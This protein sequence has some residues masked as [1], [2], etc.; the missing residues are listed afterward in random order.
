MYLALLSQTGRHQPPLALL[1]R[2]TS[3]CKPPSLCLVLGVW[4]GDSA[5]VARGSG[6]APA[7]AHRAAPSLCP[8]KSGP[9]LCFLHR[10]FRGWPRDSAHYVR[11]RTTGDGGDV[12]VP[13]G[14]DLAGFRVLRARV[15]LATYMI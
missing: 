10:N 9:G 2:K 11:L 8:G 1:N 6:R 13:V 14:S 12:E 5:F 15:E 4:S 7:P 3:S